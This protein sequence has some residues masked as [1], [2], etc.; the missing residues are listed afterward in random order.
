MNAD[1]L[2]PYSF[3]LKSFTASF[4]SK[5]GGSQFGAARDF[6]AKVDLVT[7]PGAEPQERTIRLNQPLDVN[8]ARLFLVGNG[9][10]PQITVHDG[11]GNEVWSGPVPFLATDSMYTSTGVVKMP[12]AK[13][14]QLGLFAVFLPTA[15][16]DPQTGAEVSVF[17]DDDNPKLQVYA[18]TGDLGLNDG[19]PQSVYLLD[20]SN[21]SQVKGADGKQ[22]T[23]TIAVGDSVDLPGGNG[24]VTFDGVTRYIALD[25]RYDPTKTYVLVF[26]L[27]ALA[28]V[29]A[30][31]FVRRRRVWFRVTRGADGK[32]VVA[33]AACPGPRTR[34]SPL[35]CVVS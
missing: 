7:E 16:T 33:S 15:G 13:P 26:A 8:G 21:L 3:L 24:T 14:E 17:P 32:T 34:N 35:R 30:S 27:L 6:E 5:S 10:A 11:K 23:K 1:D 31:L 28:G 2:P 12:D 29:T 20:Q 18:F 19:T 22:F 25:V 9:Y 4:E